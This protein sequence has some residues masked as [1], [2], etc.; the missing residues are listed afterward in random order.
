MLADWATELE[1]GPRIT[2]LEKLAHEIVG[3][4]KEVYYAHRRAKAN[5]AAEKTV[6]ERSL[7]IERE[8]REKIAADLASQQAA[9]AAERVALLRDKE[10]AVRDKEAAK[11]EL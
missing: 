2:L 6:A 1:L 3:L 9:W 8:A 7:A 5:R 4:Y 10:A 11:K